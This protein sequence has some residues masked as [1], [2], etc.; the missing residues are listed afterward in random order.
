MY[1]ETRDARDLALHERR[2]YP[3][4]LAWLDAV[5]A[6]Q[7]DGERFEATI[8]DISLGGALIQSGA[9]APAG[10]ELRVT[11]DGFS[12]VAKVLRSEER[13]AGMMTNLQFQRAARSSMEAVE[14]I[15]NELAQ[16]TRSVPRLAPGMRLA[17]V[18]GG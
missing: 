14:D 6:E 7:P 1:A 13:G 9:G 17:L 11:A 16:T 5:A 8:V 10:S 18:A 12:V 15:V 2:R 4:Y 3:R